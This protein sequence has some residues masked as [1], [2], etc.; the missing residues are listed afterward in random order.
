MS[1][2]ELRKVE[3]VLRQAAVSPA[4]LQELWERATEVAWWKRLPLA[5]S[6]VRHALRQ[7][8]LLL[9]CDAAKRALTAHPLDLELRRRY[10][11][12][13]AQIGNTVRAQEV[14]GELIA[15][16]H[17]DGE[18]RGLLGRTYK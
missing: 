11:T 7:G 12:G 4:V 13:L 18:T 10:A 5:R 17:G 6:F 8:E 16:G 3:Q 9:G 2:Q 1:A 15:E 14:L